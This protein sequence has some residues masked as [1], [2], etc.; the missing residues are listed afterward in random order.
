MRLTRCAAYPV[1]ITGSLTFLGNLSC[2]LALLSDPVSAIWVILAFFAI[3]QVE[4][5][6]LVP[7]I[8]GESVKLHPA[9]V[10]V[11]LVVGNE[12]AGFWGMIIAVPVTAIVRDVFKYLYLRFQDEPCAPEQA[13]TAIRSGEEVQ[14]GV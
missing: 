3:Q 6:I 4:N 12:M 2:A 1:D 11:V 7:R 8:A 10:M 9:M 13:M 5:L 14:L